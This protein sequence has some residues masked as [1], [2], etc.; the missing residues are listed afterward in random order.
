MSNVIKFV[1]YFSWQVESYAREFCA[2]VGCNCA[3]S[4]SIIDLYTFSAI[5]KC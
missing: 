2:V 3:Q 5:N 1:L 4:R